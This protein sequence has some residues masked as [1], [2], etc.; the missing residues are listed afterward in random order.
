M[1]FLSGIFRV[2]PHMIGGLEKSRFNSIEQQSLEY[3]GAFCI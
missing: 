3:Q 1:G 2:P